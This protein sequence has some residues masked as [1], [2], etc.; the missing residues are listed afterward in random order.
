MSSLTER[1]SAG[2]HPSYAYVYP[3][4]RMYNRSFL[5]QTIEEAVLTDEIGVYLHIPF[6]EQKCTF[7]GYLTL[8]ERSED[9]RDAY[10]DC[11]IKELET[12]RDLLSTKT[13]RTINIG[14]GTPSLLS[15]DQFDRIMDV[16]L[17]INP[18]IPQTAKEISIEATPESILTG[19]ALRWKARGLNRV[20]IG[21]QTLNAEE[22]THSKRKN[23]PTLSEAA[24]H[25]LREEGI[26]NICCDLMYG[27]EGQT[28]ETWQY[29]VE[30]LVYLHPQTIE[31]YATTVIPGTPLALKN[32][33][34]MSGKEKYRFY[35]HAR[36]LLLDGGYIQDCHLRF[37]IP[38][39]GAYMQQEDVFKGLSLLGFGAGARTYTPTVYWRNVFDGGNGRSA[40]IEYMRRIRN[41]ES[42]IESGVSLS[43]DE[44]MRRY[45]IFNLEALHLSTLVEMFGT[46][47]LEYINQTI[48]ELLRLDF[49]EIDDGTLY[50]NGRGIV[51]RDLIAR[52]FYSPEVI[53]KESTYWQPLFPITT[54]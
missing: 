27:L 29:S 31:L 30:R 6:C 42:P 47:A 46:H 34:E 49:A 35:T 19:K 15:T 36:D 52:E 21:I 28:Y 40:T 26:P 20:S 48:N 45:I 5:P 41:G 11:L 50:L 24:V 2:E 54:S 25:R 16:L 38:G 33:Q 13:I 17:K 9:F 1:F 3:P 37:V 10:V 32:I 7:C 14:G 22:I 43:K 23:T 18:R 51:Y 44:Q 53:E 4:T 8:I 39:R 12:R